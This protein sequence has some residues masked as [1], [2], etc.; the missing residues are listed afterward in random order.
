MNFLY[1]VA[2]LIVVLGVLIFVHELGHFL[3]AKWAG[4]RVHRFALGMGNPVPGLSF[5]RGHT[6][7]AICWLPLGGYV[8]MASREEEVASSALEG[9]R[10]TEPVPPDEVFE[11][12][13]VWKRMVVILAGVTMNILFG[14]M[15]MTWLAAK[16]G[17]E[18]DPTTRVG[19]VLADSLP[20]GAEPMARLTEGD[21]IVR[22][23]AMPITGWNDVI[24][25][26]TN[27]PDSVV[28]HL[29]DGR[30]EVARVHH[31][32]LGERLKL[33]QAILPYRAAVVGE[34]GAGEVA[35]KAGLL[36]GDTILAVNGQPV[37]QWYDL[38]E[39]IRGSAGVPLTLSVGRASGRQDLTMTPATTEEKAPDG[40]TRTFG[41][42]GIGV[43][44][45]TQY[46]RLSFGE[47]IG[48]GARATL[49][50][51]TQIFRTVQGLFTARISSKEVGGPIL[52]GQMAAQNARLGLDALLG[53]MAFVSVNLAV[54]N[55][56]P[57]P[58]LDGG[59][60]LFLLAEGVLRRPLSL[61][62]REGLTMVGLFLIVCLMVL[63][64]KNDIVR[65]WG[66]ITGW[67]S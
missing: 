36:S 13:P 30:V 48:A 67:F 62:I 21:Q 1:G 43:H 55:L 5:T 17:I 18:I 6:E 10:A 39:Q 29:A 25:A 41:R 7:Y 32:A 38:V 54:L 60:F 58:V 46:R 20:R 64:F 23:G 27:E 44:F 26:I 9:A 59:Q 47:A 28:V 33:V 4:I 50:S 49:V 3:A 56:L 51:S 66:T 8:K 31:A 65:N 37:R 19:R 35:A 45:D 16:N 15:L 61:R 2:V 34:V 22:I 14:W 42:L 57:I 63:A 40:T 11:A 53:F 12:Q 52:I 24:E